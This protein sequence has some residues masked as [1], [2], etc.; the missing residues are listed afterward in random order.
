MKVK[1]L[2]WKK[3]S[4]VLG[5]LVLIGTTITVLQPYRF[6]AWASDLRQVA[7]V[8]YDTAINWEQDWLRKT[9]REIDKCRVDEDCPLPY[10]HR[11][12]RDEQETLDKIKNLKEEREGLLKKGKGK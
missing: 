7:E 4:V 8:S 12:E 3:I 10:V 5:G 1:L 11:L 2:T 9:Q 6:W